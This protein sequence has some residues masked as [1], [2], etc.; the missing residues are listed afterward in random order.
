MPVLLVINYAALIDDPNE[1]ESL[2]VPFEMMR[3]GIQCD[4]T[5]RN[6]G[7]EGCML[8]DEEC[9]N[10]GWDEEKLFLSILKPDDKDMEELECFELNSPL[11]L[12]T[13]IP[14]HYPEEV[15]E[16]STVKRNSLE[17]YHRQNKNK[18]KKDRKQPKRNRK[19][20]TSSEYTSD[21]MDKENG[22]VT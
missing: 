9:F 7:G 20:G 18:L 16:N 19:K 14:I 22:N 11:P 8:V 10:F 15:P 6:L 1:C 3:H 5:P 2:I 21:R 12:E 4:L 17:K 13:R